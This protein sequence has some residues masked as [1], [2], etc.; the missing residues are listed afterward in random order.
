MNLRFL[1]TVILLSET[2]SLVA[3]ARR[4]GVS[5]SAV[6]LQLKAL[7]EELRFPILDRST[8]P[9]RLTDDGLSV[10]EYGRQILNLAEDLQEIG[11]TDILVGSVK[12]GVVPSAL[13][14]LMPPALANLRNLHP[15]LNV[16][17]ESGLSE[18]L[19]PKLLSRQLDI[20]LLTQPNLMPEGVDERVICDEP[21]DFVAAVDQYDAGIDKL[22]SSHPFILFSRQT[23]TGKQVERYLR[24]Q[25]LPVQIAMEIDS[26]DAIEALVANGLGVSILPRRVGFVQENQ[27]LTRIPLVCPP[28]VRTMSLM[29]LERSPR[30][31]VAD[32]LEVELKRIVEENSESDLGEMRKA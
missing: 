1:Q 24:Q 2:G 18:T 29:R 14:K 13:M 20:A 27:N 8:R 9:P 4:L 11:E 10:V 26:I 30:K 22:M 3:T 17:I 28:L 5:H 12:I 32:A 19:L 6:S 7:E 23:W 31:R 16:N 25:K 15:K 21:L